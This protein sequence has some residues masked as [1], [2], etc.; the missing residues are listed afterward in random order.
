LQEEII[1]FEL[2]KKKLESEIKLREAARSVITKN[3]M[4]LE[5]TKATLLTSVSD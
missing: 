5:S 3:M 2:T 4:E 1:K